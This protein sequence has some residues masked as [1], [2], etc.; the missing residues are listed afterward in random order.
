MVVGW[1]SPCRCS[2]APDEGEKFTAWLLF[3]YCQH[4]TDVMPIRVH[5]SNSDTIFE[6]VRS[7]CRSHRAYSSP[8]LHE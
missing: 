7:V 6:D 5:H 1:Q 4:L 8:Q 3:G 2:L